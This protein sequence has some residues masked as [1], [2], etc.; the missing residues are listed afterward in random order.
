M[1]MSWGNMLVLCAIDHWNFFR[2]DSCN[3][4]KSKKKVKLTLDKIK[5]NILVFAKQLNNTLRALW[6]DNKK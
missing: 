2:N 5:Y 1:L 6:L 3:A 4:I